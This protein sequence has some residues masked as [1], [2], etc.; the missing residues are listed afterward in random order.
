MDLHRVEG[1]KVLWIHCWRVPVL[2][3]WRLSKLR[4][5]VLFWASLHD[6]DYVAVYIYISATG[7][8]FLETVM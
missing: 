7:V 6:E 3:I 8:H 5:W 4:G 2:R 1:V